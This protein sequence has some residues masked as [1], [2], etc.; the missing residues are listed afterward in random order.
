MKKL[1][2]KFCILALISL[3]IGSNANK[4]NQ[5]YMQPV[6]VVDKT[7]VGQVDANF[8]FQGVKD[9][10][11]MEPHEAIAEEA[12]IENKPIPIPSPTT[13]PIKAENQEITQTKAESTTTVAPNV[14]PTAAPVPTSTPNSVIAQTTAPTVVPAKTTEPT[15][16]PQP[17][18]APTPEPQF[19]ISYWIGFAQ[20]Y[21]QSIGLVLESSVVDCWDNPIP[22]GNHCCISNRILPIG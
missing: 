3:L 5:E 22:A 12:E 14:E 18:I 2:K 16:T 8:S 10:E 21:A 13:A 20:D 17:T 7:V 15:P 1:F 11:A 6:D 19:D 9:P 4:E